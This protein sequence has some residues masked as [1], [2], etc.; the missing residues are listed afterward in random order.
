[1]SWRQQHRHQDLITAGL[2]WA[3][4]RV[5]VVAAFVITDA[6]LDRIEPRPEAPVDLGLLAWD[7]DWYRRIAEVG[8]AGA[9][10]PAIRFFPLWP[11]LGRWAGAL[12]GGPELALVVLANLS[13][14]VCTVLLYRLTSEVTGDHE[15][16]ARTVRLFSLFPTAFV[17]VLGYSEALFL[18]FSLAMLL[19]LR[20]QHWWSAAALGFLAGLTRPLGALLGLCAAVVMRRS[21]VRSV[22]GWAAVLS[23]PLGTASFLAYSGLAFDDPWAPFDRQRE[24][25]GSFAE[26]VSRLVTAAADGMA[27]DRGEAFHVLAAVILA[28]LCVVC[29][30]R[31]APELWI[32][33]VASTLLMISVENLN[34]I[35]RYA[36]GAFPLV[37]AAAMV[38]RSRFFDRWLTT[39]SAVAMTSVCV[40]ALGGVYVP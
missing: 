24:L 8:Y 23:G 31:L 7:G 27:G 28:A 29:V 21:G 4:A 9:D 30:R 36:L 3:E 40:L 5:Y 32:Y 2:A 38:S 10:D 33:A 15:T 37:I 6:V 20:K 19:A 26:P 13:A 34:S 11:L 1:M 25:R 39:A 22:G 35:E 12:L 18:V 17:L 14:L 16:A